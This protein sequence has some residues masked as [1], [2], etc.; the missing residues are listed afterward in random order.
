MADA[1]LEA[2][3]AEAA[4]GVAQVLAGASVETSVLVAVAV[5]EAAGLALPAV[6]ASADKVGVAV[7]AEAVV[8]TG[9]RGALVAICHY[10]QKEA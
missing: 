3:R 10:T 7:L 8:L 1:A 6:A 5:P 4:E 9:V 2:E